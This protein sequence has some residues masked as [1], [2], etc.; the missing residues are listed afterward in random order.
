MQLTNGAIRTTAP[1]LPL[2][3]Q[4]ST[5][6]LE[7]V[8]LETFDLSAFIVKGL[9][10]D[11]TP[12]KPAINPD[13]QRFMTESEQLFKLG[14]QYEIEVVERG[15][16]ALY[17]LLAS[18]YSL[19]LRVEE[20]PHRDNIVEAIRTDLKDKH[21]ISIQANSSPIAAMVRYVVRTDKVNATRYVK[22]LTVAREESIS[23]VDLPAYITRRGGVSQAQEK[24]SV[25]VSK[26]AG[27]KS[28]KER[29][30]LIREFYSLMGMTSSMDFQYN[31]EVN[32]HNEGKDK[33]SEA[34]SFCVFM[35][36]HVGADKYKM[37][38][39]N[40][41]G[42]SWEDNL[43]KFLGKGMPN[44]LYLLETGIRNYK[45]RI[46]QD[47]LQPESLRR[48]METQLAI[49]MKYKQMETIDMEPISEDKGE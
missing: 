32:L 43:V 45:R 33:D 40:D 19:A 20:S 34:S 22:V 47:P 23:V 31:G 44:N 12:S 9:T 4:L 15:H 7:G 37:I 29:T 26:K 14:E 30:A 3:Q 27:D 39:A 28:T 42:R 1:Q 21:S 36:H 18:I 8:D 41:L 6:E 13:V 25:A 46:A 2:T 16:Q 10:K 49:P 5:Q 24:E 38:S 48:E 17:E 35:A 11:K